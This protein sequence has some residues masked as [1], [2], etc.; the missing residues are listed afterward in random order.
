MLLIKKTISCRTYALNMEICVEGY[1]LENGITVQYL[2]GKWLD[3]EGREY[4]EVTT[5][6]GEL[7]CFEEI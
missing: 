5:I 7:V 3:A 6:D 2:E 4:L 1:E